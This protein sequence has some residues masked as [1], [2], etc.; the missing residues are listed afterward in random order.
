MTKNDLK[1]SLSEKIT[2]VSMLTNYFQAEIPVSEA[3]SL[4]QQD[5]SNRKIK[6]LAHSLTSAIAKGNSLYKALDKFHD[7][8]GDIFMAIARAA[9]ESGAI[10]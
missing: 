2:F 8:L 1:L 6:Y 9:E 3:L 10:D 7:T 5:C 4:V